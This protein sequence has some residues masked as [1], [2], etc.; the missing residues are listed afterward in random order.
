MKRPI[1]LFDMMRFQFGEIEELIAYG[2]STKY[3]ELDDFSVLLKFKN[4]FHCDV[5]LRRRMQAG[6]FPFE[7]IEVF[8]A[9]P[10]DFDRGNGATLDRKSRHKTKISRR[11]R[12]IC[13]RK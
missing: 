12:V 13:S 3:P 11:F 4:G 2:S 6:I 10:D 9:S 8:C 5:S 1:H 7:R